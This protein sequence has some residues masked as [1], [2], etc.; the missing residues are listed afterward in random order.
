MGA[1]ED[2]LDDMKVP[3]EDREL[4]VTAFVAKHP[5]VHDAVI[6]RKVY[7][8]KLDEMAD[9]RKELDGWRKEGEK[10]DKV[11]G[12]WNFEIKAERDQEALNQRIQALQTALEAGGDMNFDEVLTGL[13][14]KGV[15]LRDEMPALVQKTVAEGA[16]GKPL[17][18][19]D[20][21][22]R[23]G[24][25]S[26]SFET[27]YGRATPLMMRYAKDFDGAEF[28]LSEFIQF[29]GN[30]PVSALKSS[31]SKSGWDEV[32]ECYKVFTE[33]KRSQIEVDRLKKEAADAQEELKQMREK[34]QSRSQPDDT[35]GNTPQAMG[36]FARRL[37]EQ[38]KA[39]AGGTVD[40]SANA[41]LGD[42]QSTAAGLEAL[43]AGALVTADQ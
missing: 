17:W 6:R 13:K 9:D 19:D 35:G 32:D 7:N 1:F 23:I 39:A 3:T 4:P 26:Y 34:S 5:E 43:K 25:L 36:P 38:R 37:A 16:N 10:Y 29:T 15:V 8:Q 27:I 30:R 33:G 22:G 24:N 18:D 21:R 2:I 20:V 12:K 31:G 28:P 11:A 42:G 14:D 40:P 41:K